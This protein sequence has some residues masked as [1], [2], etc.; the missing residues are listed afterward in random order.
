MKSQPSWQSIPPP[1]YYSQL[2]TEIESLG[3]DK[4]DMFTTYC[5]GSC[6]HLGVSCILY[7]GKILTQFLS[8]PCGHFCETLQGCK[9]R[10]LSVHIFSK[11]LYC[12][13]K[14]RNHSGLSLLRTCM[15]FVSCHSCLLLMLFNIWSSIVITRAK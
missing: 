3:W 6:F 5:F 8:E 12:S 9:L 10:S 2:I 11:F 13:S 14:Q 4:Y 1:Q 7:V 15:S